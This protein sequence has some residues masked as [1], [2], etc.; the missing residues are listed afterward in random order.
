MPERQRDFLSD[1]FQTVAERSR[2]LLRLQD[3]GAVQLSAQALAEALLSTRGEASGV[4]L[5]RALLDRW[6]TMTAGERSDWFQFLARDLGPDPDAVSRA[7]AQ[8]SEDPAPA[9]ASRLH[10][11]AE[12]RRQELLRRMN[13][14]P[15]GTAMLVKMR[16]AL[17][18]EV[19]ARPELAPVDADLQHLFT[20]WFNRGFLSLKRIDWS[21]P[22]DILEKIILYEAVHEIHG[23]DDLKSRLQ[24]ADRHCFAFFHPQVPDEP[25]VFVEVALTRGM[26]SVIGG[27][28]DAGRQ[29]IPEAEADTAVFYSISNTQDGLRGISFGNFLIKQVVEELVREVP[30]L[31]TFVTLSPVPGFAAWLAAQREEGEEARLPA[32]LFALLGEPGW[33]GADGTRAALRPLLEQAAALYLLAAKDRNGKPADPVARFHLNNGAALERINFCG[34]TSPKGMRQSHGI[35]V[36]YLYDLGAIERNHEAY[37]NHGEVAASAAVRRMLTSEE[38][39]SLTRGLQALLPPRNT[40]KGNGG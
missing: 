27:V 31:K 22:A 34:D 3:S 9:N 8:W 35:M 39:G 16:E 20:S 32:Q 28:I 13:L 25:L 36:N 40:R 14:A 15:G 21:T 11:A 17:L 6:Q 30:G 38:P 4:A 23:W 26:P 24:P 19:K 37:A 10:Q 12:P 33:E 5:S 2:K 18:G 1:L 7:V 29:P